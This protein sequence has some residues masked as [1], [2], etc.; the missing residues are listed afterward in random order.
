[1]SATLAAGAAAERG[2]LL[3][4]DREGMRVAI[5]AEGHDHMREVFRKIRAGEM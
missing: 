2:V 4:E 5:A 3:W 1:M